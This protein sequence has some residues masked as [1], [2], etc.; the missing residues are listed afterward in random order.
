MVLLTLTVGIRTSADPENGLC[1]NTSK[2]NK[3]TTFFMRFVARG[4]VKMQ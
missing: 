2:T 1:Q 4:K 3:I